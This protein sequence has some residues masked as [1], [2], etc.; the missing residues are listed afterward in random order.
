MSEV[1]RCPACD[2]PFTP[3]WGW[4]KYCTKDCQNFARV[5]GTR[6]WRRRFPEKSQDSGRRS[7]QKWVS[8]HREKQRAKNRVQFALLAAAMA[9]YKLERGCA[10]C[11]YKAHSA[12]LHFDH[13][14]GEKFG[15]V[16][17]SPSLSWFRQEAE[18][19]DVVCANC[20][21]VRTYERLQVRKRIG[22]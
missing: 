7:M 17:Q 8:G 11:G 14:R 19:C 9:E 5:Q 21:A 3:E 18:K 12:A 10:D 13:V 1:R 16:S 22:K 6:A 20:H 2:M 4:Q 15:N